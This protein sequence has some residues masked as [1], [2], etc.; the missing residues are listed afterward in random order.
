L[1]SRELSYRA[2]GDDKGVSELASEEKLNLFT[3]LSSLKTKLQ[4]GECEPSIVLNEADKP[5]E[6]SFLPIMQYENALKVI[7]KE[8]VRSGDRRS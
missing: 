3:E 7:K 1:L 2:C 5:M 6:F 8:N 4:S